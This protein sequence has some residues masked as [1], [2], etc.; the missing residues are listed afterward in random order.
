LSIYR[1]ARCTVWDWSETQ[2]TS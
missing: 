1:P 2:I